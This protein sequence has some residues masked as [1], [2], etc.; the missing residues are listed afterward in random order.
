MLIRVT[1]ARQFIDWVLM[2]GVGGNN[3]IEDEFCPNGGEADI[4]I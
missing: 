4:K 3:V 1:E 2:G